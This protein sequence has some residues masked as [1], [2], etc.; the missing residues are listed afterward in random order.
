[1]EIVRGGQIILMSW[2]LSLR[3]ADGRFCKVNTVT[4]NEELG[5]IEY[6]LSDKTGTLTVNKMEFIT[7]NIAGNTFGGNF[8]MNDGHVSF[9]NI[10]RKKKIPFDECNLKDFDENLYHMLNKLKPSSLNEQ[11]QSSDLPTRDHIKIE[12]DDTNPK[13]SEKCETANFKLGNKE[14]SIS[15]LIKLMFNS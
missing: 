7:C 4:I 10:L 9:N 1:M 2:N 3:S 14:F 12:L 15:D 5:N 13:L 8:Y 11:Q 6:I